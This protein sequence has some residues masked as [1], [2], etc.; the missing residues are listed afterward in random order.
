MTD[1]SRPPSK[2]STIPLPPPPPPPAPTARPQV[3]APATTPSYPQELLDAIRATADMDLNGDRV[4]TGE[5]I[6][7]SAQA[8]RAVEQATGETLQ[9]SPL[10]RNL[11]SICADVTF[12]RTSDV[13]QP[14]RDASLDAYFTENLLGLRQGNRPE[15]IQNFVRGV[16][17][18][19]AENGVAQPALRNHE[20]SMGTALR[21]GTLNRELA[22]LPAI[23]ANISHI[24]ICE[25]LSIHPDTSTQPL[26]PSLPVPRTATPPRRT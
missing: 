24:D 7:R 26:P 9:I 5:E 14:E 21:N 18:H 16:G 25:A 22:G 12:H 13:P 19:L 3:A 4:L 11:Q 17:T 23:A 2:D 8:A 10:L 1:K 15:A 20:R 6:R